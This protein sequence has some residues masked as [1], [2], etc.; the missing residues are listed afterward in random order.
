MGNVSLSGCLLRPIIIL[1]EIANTPWDSAQT[2]ESRLPDL[3]T[4]LHPHPGV[5]PAASQ[6][7]IL[8]SPSVRDP[9]V[10]M[11]VNLRA[12]GRVFCGLSP[13]TGPLGQAEFSPT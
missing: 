11:C 10:R 4:T 12:E 5:V 3:S 9:A 1:P 13:V 8:C 6:L 7:H 2:T